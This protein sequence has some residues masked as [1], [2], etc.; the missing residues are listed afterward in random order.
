MSYY[1]FSLA[2]SYRLLAFGAEI[3]LYPSQLASFLSPSV[4]LSVS[5]RMDLV[6]VLLKCYVYCPRSGRHP[7]RL[8]KSLHSPKVSRTVT[9][10][11]RTTFPRFQLSTGVLLFLVRT[12]RNKKTVA[13]F[14]C[15][16][17]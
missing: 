14:V 15:P 8:L 4:L 17:P 3:W 13:L 7:P 6:N 11:R 10:V 12:H 5:Y 16:N 1:G 9:P 2:T